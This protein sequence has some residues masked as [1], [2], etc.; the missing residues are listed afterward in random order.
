M[1][2]VPVAGGTNGAAGRTDLSPMRS[3]WA[4]APALAHDLESVQGIIDGVA[5]EASSSIRG[6]LADTVGNTGKMLRPALVILSA[7]AGRR[8]TS[9]RRAAGLVRV[10]TEEPLGFSGTPDEKMYRIAAAV[11]ILHMATL[12]HDDVIDG[13]DTRRGAPALHT[14]QGNRRAILMGDFLFSSCFTL[15]AE[16]AAMENARTLAA[17]V[18]HICRSQIDESLPTASGPRTPREYYRQVAAKTALLFL[19]SCHV[20]ASESS[21][22]LEDAQALRRFGYNLGMTFQ[23]VD[24]LLDLTGTQEELGKPVGTDLKSRVLTLPII[25]ALESDDGELSALLRRGVDD[26]QVPRAVSL[27]EE[28]GGIERARLAAARHT[29]R[30]RRELALLSASEARDT[31]S[32]LLGRLLNRRR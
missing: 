21:V 27:I 5:R 30:A 18:R 20:G 32:W 26:D 16:D 22:A 19:L 28:R 3:F 7:R 14:V 8:A 25:Y 29:E 6:V 24:D 10:R 4:G 31:L 15:L 2:P 1:D 9:R 23:V 13:A 17:G 11:E 12:I